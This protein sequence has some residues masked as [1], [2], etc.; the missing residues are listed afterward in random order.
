MLT[1]QKRIVVSFLLVIAGFIAYHFTVVPLVEPSYSLKAA[2][3]L[4]DKEIEIIKKRQWER[5]SAYRR[6]FAHDSW[7]WND[8]PLVLESDRSKLL[9]KEYHNVSERKVELKPCAVLFLP[10][11]EPA[12]GQMPGRAIVLEAPQGAVLEFDR[13]VDLQR[14]KIGQVVGGVMDGPITITAPESRPGANDAIHV[15]T[16]DAKMTLDQ[17]WTEA[18]VE[19]SLGPSHGTGRALV[20]HL[21]PAGS[22]HKAGSGVDSL[23]LLH[24]VQMQLVP[25]EHGIMPLDNAAANSRQN[26][27][28]SA[29]AGSGPGASPQAA[30]ANKAPLGANLPVNV[31][32][33]GTFRFDMVSY[34]ATFDK[35]VD[36]TRVMPGGP[37][38]DMTC[39][40]LHV[41]F[42]PKAKP[43]AAAV[44]AGAGATSTAAADGKAKAGD[45]APSNASA[46][47]SPVNPDAPTQKMPSLEPRRLQAIGKPVLVRGQINGVFAQCEQLDYDIVTRQISLMGGQ[48]VHLLQNANEIH[49]RSVVYL[50]DPQGKLGQLEAVGPGWLRGLANGG[51]A[52]APG[53]TGGTSLPSM[54]LLGSPGGG[55]AQRPAAPLYAPENRSVL[56]LFAG[57]TPAAAQPGPPP[58]VFEAHWSKELKMRP[59]EQ[60]Q[61]ISLLGAA[62]ASVSGQ[63]AL[64]GEEIHLWLL[65]TPDES[66]PRPAAPP[67]SADAANQPIHWKT[68][69]DRL[70]AKGTVTIDSPQLVGRTDRLEAWF[71]PPATPPGTPQ[72]PAPLA[73]RPFAPVSYPGQTG[74]PLGPLSSPIA[75]PPPVGRDQSRQRG[76]APQGPPA[77]PQQYS[78]EGDRIRLRLLLADKGAQP[79]D[80]N[81]DGRVRFA[82]THTATPTDKPL[83]ITGA[84]LQ[85]TAANTPSTLAIVVGQP[86]MVGA[87]G[88]DLYGDAVQ[89]D[90][91]ANRVWIDGPGRMVIANT[92][93][94]AK[95][96][97]QLTGAAPLGQSTTGQTLTAPAGAMAHG[98]AGASGNGATA[99]SNADDSPPDEY[100]APEDRAASV[101]RSP[102]ASDGDP[103]VVTWQG[104]MNFDGATARF[105]KQIVGKSTERNFTCDTLDA[106]LRQRIDFNQPS[107]SGRAEIGRFVCHG[108]TL[109]ENRTSDY[110]GLTAVDRMNVRDLMVDQVTGA[111]LGQGPGWLVSVRKGSPDPTTTAG[112]ASP[113]APGQPPGGAPNRPTG[114][115]APTTPFRPTAWTGS[116]PPTAYAATPVANRKPGDRKPG[117]SGAKKHSGAKKDQR[118][119]Q[120]DQQLNYLHVT[121][122]GPLS[123]NLTR[124]ELTFHKEVR[125]IYGP[126]L[127]WQDELDLDSV[128][129]LGPGDVQ[130]STDELTVRDSADP[131]P[132]QPTSVNGAPPQRKPIEMEATGNTVVDVQAFT[133]RCYRMT[134]AESK[135]LLTFDG[136]GRNDAKL[137]RQ[138]HPGD[139][140]SETAARTIQFWRTA[141]RLRVDGARVI[142]LNQLPAE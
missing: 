101:M 78:V 42:A 95:P 126:V 21:T 28:E 76:A 104:K 60:N 61:V 89:L 121:F 30:G 75:G 56:N 113:G 19:F 115:A 57:N 51:G 5:L 45:T 47:A 44:A 139:P 49:A 16:R 2:D 79:Q 3:G 132:P 118:V 26:K 125:T 12:D 7:E 102:P 23:E 111:I 103:M 13:E 50:P 67:T 48:E 134:Y 71:E 52:S 120:T 43:P 34:V 99:P 74:S 84:Q 136:D 127:S 141:N 129:D 122:Q 100:L 91:A 40:R 14:G 35:A 69:P 88:M 72:A 97:V 70:F 59:S 105:E 27:P 41:F 8:Q 33:Q 32:C 73:S 4:S 81:I 24:D 62:K 137:F 83:V 93:P 64:A 15:V 6:Y 106:T 31:R 39:D 20:M 77:P 131:L 124:H 10:D 87:R 123:G 29:V 130:M 65:Q 138:E 55:G 18:P 128:D 1:Q 68:T 9:T 140:V 119:G 46:T 37:T 142:D 54:N 109:L 135:D 92:S 36:V 25:G 22:G 133:A 53:A 66:A 98:G 17:I 38:D 85:V 110:T 108:P 86:A 107:S 117:D 11:G 80:I 112:T 94:G 114:A 63:G 96:A 82:E 90:K 58:S 116:K